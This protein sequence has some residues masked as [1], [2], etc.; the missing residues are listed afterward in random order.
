MGH[1]Y[2]FSMIALFV[3]LVLNE[4]NFKNKKLYSFILGIL[5]GIIF[6]I[7]SINIFVLLVYVLYKVFDL[8]TFKIRLK[9]IFSY[10]RLPFNI[11]GFLIPLSMQIAYWYKISGKLFLNPYYNEHF[12]FL[13][14]PKIFSVLFGSTKGLFFYAPILLII[15]FG[16]KEFKRQYK[17][18]VLGSIIFLILTTYLISSW[19]IGWAQGDS[20]SSR[21][22]ADYYSI[23]MLIFASSLNFILKNKLYKKLFFIFATICLIYTNFLF[24]MYIVHALP[25]ESGLNSIKD[26]FSFRYVK[27]KFFARI[28]KIGNKKYILYD[29][30]YNKIP[31]LEYPKGKYRVSIQGKNLSKG[32]Y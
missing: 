16:F 24:F 25:C 3:F 11:I 5:S 30:R 31:Y 32:V 14:N 12:S 23:L 10:E 8:K 2:S 21:M 22:H 17:N 9:E 1:L 27:S 19:W 20:F 29:A 26:I 7:K 4:D 13:L 18:I 6:L 28:E 15:F